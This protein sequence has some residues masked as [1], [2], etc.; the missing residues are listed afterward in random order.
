MSRS[1]LEAVYADELRS[2]EL[3]KTQIE[4][5]IQNG[6]LPQKMSMPLG[7]QLELTSACNLRCLHCYNRSEKDLNSTND[8]T[9]TDWINIANDIVASGGV[10]QAI[11]SGGEPLLLGES[12]F[13]IM[14][15]FHDSG[16]RFIL[17]SNG[18][19]MDRTKIQRLMKYKFAWLQISID[20][21]TA[22]E[23]D[24][25]RMKTGSWKRAVNASVNISNAGIPL[26]IASTIRPTDIYKLNEYATQAYQLGAS[27]LILGDIMPSGRAIENDHLIMNEEQKSFFLNEI[28][29][30]RKKWKD[31]LDIQS[32]S[33]VSLQLAQASMGTIDS[34]I[35]RP[36]GDIR[37]DCIAPFVLGNVND[38]HFKQIWD[39]LPGDVWQHPSVQEYISQVEL[40]S[41]HSSG[42]RNY[43][44]QD[45]H[46]KF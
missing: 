24:N 33:F 28:V 1:F 4:S 45:I 2:V 22:Q 43:L 35:I 39:K 14:D 20:G 32:S 36:N 40:Y 23:H 3:Q 10:F 5:L 44:D 31:V 38:T 7:I 6:D 46:L 37:L 12:L 41:G 9:P 17:I 18:Y 15:V 29:E 21:I 27:S 42:V 8:L 19:L 26:K 16:C 30:L 11:I 25:F 13:D 34:V